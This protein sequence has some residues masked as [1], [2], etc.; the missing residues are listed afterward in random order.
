[1]P[2]FCEN[3]LTISG[4]DVERVLAA[5]RDLES[6]D[7]DEHILDFD[8]IVPY[9]QELKDLDQRNAEYQAKFFAI[10]KDDPDRDEKLKALADKYG[11]EPGTPWLKDGYNS[12]GY[13]WCIEQWGCYDDKTEV[14][15]KDGWKFFQNVKPDDIFFTLNVNGDIEL[16]RSLKYVAKPYRGIMYH[17][18]TK[19]IDIKVTPDHNMF[20][21]SPRT[22]NYRFIAAKD[23]PYCRVKIKQVGRWSGEEKS[24]FT[25]PLERRAQRT[26]R[27]RHLNMDDFLEFL[28]YYISE[29]SLN[30]ANSK[31]GGNQY[32][33]RISQ[34]K[35][36]GLTKIMENIRRLNLKMYY[37]GKDIIINDFQ[38]Y[39][40]L[41]QFGYSHEK[42]I[43]NDIKK[44]SPRQLKILLDALL[45][46]D[47]TK[48]KYGSYIYYTTSKRLADD[49]QEI[50]LKAGYITSVHMDDR[51]G[52]L[53]TNGY[54]YNHICYYVCLYVNNSKVG[55]NVQKHQITQTKYDGTIYC[56]VVPNHT[57][58]VRRDGK[59]AWCG[60]TKWNAIRVSLTKRPANIPP[61]EIATCA[62]C[63]IQ[64]RTAG[65]TV[66]VCQKC[67]AP[68]PDTRP[69][70]ALVEF[71]TA[72][73][74]PEAVI[75]KLAAMFPD[76]DFELE[77][78]EGGV[79]FC[80]QARWSGG[81]EQYH[82][83]SEYAGSRGG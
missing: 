7:P 51:R 11:V 26:F 70:V 76:H 18:K 57:L 24:M 20:V 66:L 69:I 80:G 67:G 47:G 52:K 21:A 64:H 9:P 68:L 22:S 38:L 1:M 48:R 44:L 12:G 49:V 3:E 34:Y 2:N 5:M 53:N 25:L 37:Y 8:K 62:H 83:T 30:K 60:N 41:E 71:E 50:G 72:W 59:V 6:D 31:R 42:Y 23:I 4:P 27:E 36:E 29:G 15:T 39:L 28:G 19:L 45:L 61:V 10:A 65:M 46:G 54:N 16:H 78:Y 73:S 14:L 82:N 33:V 77:Y 75:E 17:F 32:Y 13:E 79:G 43:P 40:Y 55:S 63:Q 56:V 58:F 35:T 74:P 81:Q